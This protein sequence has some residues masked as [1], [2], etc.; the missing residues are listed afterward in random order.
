MV[1]S[2]H[3]LCDRFMTN[4]GVTRLSSQISC[5]GPNEHNHK[6]MDG[7]VDGSMVGW[8]TVHGELLLFTRDEEGAQM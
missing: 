4:P 3:L 1:V 2:L 8:N 7:W 6:K 5:D